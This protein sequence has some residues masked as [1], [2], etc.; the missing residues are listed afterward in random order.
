MQ[1]VSFDRRYNKTPID[2]ARVKL[3]LAPPK[4]NETIAII[5][6]DSN[7]SFRFSGQGK[8][9]AALDRAKQDAAKL[10]ANGLLLQSLGESGSM[11]VGNAYTTG[12]STS[13]TTSFVGVS[14]G[15]LIKTL[16]VIAI[17]VTD[18]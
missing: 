18:E 1:H 12:S 13:S 16:S 10:G 4:H 11:T 2:P 14:E 8:V 5:S 3:Y 6:T 15:G 9:D 17:Y 7:G